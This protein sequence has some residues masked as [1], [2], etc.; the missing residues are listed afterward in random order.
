MET[1]SNRRPRRITTRRVDVENH[2]FSMSGTW[3]HFLHCGT[4]I[5]IPLSAPPRICKH[6]HLPVKMTG[7]RSRRVWCYMK[8]FKVRYMWTSNDSLYCS[9]T[10]TL[11]VVVSEGEPMMRRMWGKELLNEDDVLI[12]IHRFV[13]FIFVLH[14]HSILRWSRRRWWRHFR[15]ERIDLKITVTAFGF[16]ILEPQIRWW[17]GSEWCCVFEMLS[18]KV[19]RRWMD[20]V[21]EQSLFAEITDEEK[22]GKSSLLRKGGDCTLKQT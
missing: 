12:I 3:H 6:F 13:F 7:F 18:G 10:D 22:G 15:W 8:L 1:W 2:N 19:S 14:F 4:C 16:F 9:S 5:I 17:Q 11:V 20:G 21:D